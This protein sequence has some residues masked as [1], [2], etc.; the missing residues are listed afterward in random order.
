MSELPN[1]S[2]SHAFPA[3]SAS[4]LVRGTVIE[5]ALGARKIETLKLGDLI[6]TADSGLHPLRSINR[7]RSSGC[8]PV[9]VAAGVL[10]NPAP[11]YLAPQHRVLITGWQAELYFG[12]QDVLVEVRSLIN[13]STVT[14]CADTAVEYFS[15]GFDTHQIILAEGAAVESD[16]PH[17]DGSF[18]QA[19]M[20]RAGSAPAHMLARQTVDPTEALVFSL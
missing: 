11:L 9:R 2:F 1:A 5:T 14:K 4:G 6:E 20:P 3:I 17:A 10:G 8:A 16:L 13:G 12:L 19:M 15:L 18:E 7:Q